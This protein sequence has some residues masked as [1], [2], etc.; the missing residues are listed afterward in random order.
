MSLHKSLVIL[1]MTLTVG[2]QALASQRPAAELT[3][4]PGQ[5]DVR[6]FG[7]KGDGTALDTQAIQA[8]IR[9]ANKA[10]G[11]TVAF[12]P[13]IYVTG[14]FELLSNVTLDVEA[15]GVIDRKGVLDL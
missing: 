5:F 15:G 3:S 14:T 7:T 2:V 12:P 13:G 8:A 4:P 6:A 9:A 10:G 11:G 1:G